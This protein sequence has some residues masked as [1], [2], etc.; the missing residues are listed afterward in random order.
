MKN[1]KPKPLQLGEEYI[2]VDEDSI[3]AEM[4]NEMQEQ[5]ERMYANKKMLRQIHTKMHGCVKGRF[6]IES[7]LNESYKIGI[8]KNTK[9]FP[10]W[11]RFSNSQTKPQ[12][13]KKKDI[14][15]IAIKLLGVPGEKILNDKKNATTQDFLLMSSETFFSKNIKEFRGTLKSSTAKSKLKL[16]LYF[17]NPKHWGL[18]KRL[19]GTFVKCKNPLAIPYWST[20]PYQFGS[21][22]KAVKYYLKPVETNVIVN[23]NTKEP[24]YLKTNLAQTLNN[25]AAKFDFFVQFQTNAVSM[26]IENPTIAWD[27]PYIKLATLEILPQ[28]FCSNKQLEFGENLSFNSWHT[29]PEHKPLGSFNR[30]RKRVYEAMS[31]F[32]HKANKIPDKEPIAESN[33]FED[34]LETSE[35]IITK[36]IPSKRVLKRSAQITI[37]CTKATAFQFISCNQEIP[38]WLKQYK[39][40]P[41]AIYAETIKDTYNQPGAVRKVHFDH[42]ESVIEELLSYNPNANYSYK[43]TN[44]TSKLKH[45][46]KA[47]YGQV[48]FNTINDKTHI[49]WDYT[50]TYKNI[51]ARILLSMVLTLAFK[52][53]M[54]SSLKHAKQYIENGD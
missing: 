16:T 17:A 53:F 54:Q 49:T 18:L 1:K 25:H 43:I 15:G 21:L 12:A 5:M 36:K 8:F 38:N 45:L 30:A 7:N 23:Q 24:N 47:A 29:L 44:F 34:I 3:I 52:K 26:P 50:F 27:S 22:D 42:N 20:Q 48:W 31:A 33:F 6:N 28:E 19:M 37:N 46:T 13:D 14:R 11:V 2:C 35:N 41:A 9:S 40:I 39:S 51:F 32:R 4:V 10:C